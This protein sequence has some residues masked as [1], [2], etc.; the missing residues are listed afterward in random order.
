MSEILIRFSN[1]CEA[2]KR[3]VFDV[4]FGEFLG[5]KYKIEID[6][7]N[8]YEISF[9]DK[10]VIIKDELFSRFPRYL[11]HDSIPKNI[12]YFRE[13]PI[14]Y[15]EPNIRY[16]ERECVCDIDLIGSIFF[17]LSRFEE[18]L[19][20]DA[21]KF[22]RFKEAEMLCIKYKFSHL[23]VVNYYTQWLWELVQYLEPKA[24]KK[25]HS[26][27]ILPTHDIDEFF[28]YT[29]DSLLRRMQRAIKLYGNYKQAFA[30]LKEFVKIKLG[31]QKD[32][33]DKFD[34]FMNLSEKYGTKSHFF[35]MSGGR[36][37]Y[38]NRYHINAPNVKKMMKKIKH[39]E[40]FIG[41]HPSYDSYNNFEMLRD[42]KEALKQASKTP[43]TSG[44]QHYLRFDTPLTWQLW[45]QNQMVW[46]SS[47]GFA[48]SVGFRCGVC[49]PFSVFDVKEQKHLKL[50]EHPLIIMDCALPRSKDD[51][52]AEF[53]GCV[54]NLS[55]EVRKFEG[56]M[57]VLWH[58][59][60]FSFYDWAGHD[61][62][63]ETLLS[64]IAPT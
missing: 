22:G 34:Y 53:V 9:D 26:Y 13:I 15:G 35:F 60:S 58:N 38:D 62:M 37:R 11:T 40:H 30:E 10:K 21:D 27:S 48:E 36:T 42:E 43:I 4:V 51:H 5:L 45:E 25:R 29:R 61:D 57:V 41:I 7:I 16:S 59:S 56:E 6:T 20:H 19:E 49:Y 47:M 52:R 28:F 50:I 31:I 32:P 24:A 12:K 54:R 18:S 17:M 8:D 44:R 23:P 1:I 39:R 64:I 63:Y 14:L 46:D 3:Y 33:Y 2:E 55:D